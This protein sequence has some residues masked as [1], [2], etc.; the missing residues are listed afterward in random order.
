MTAEHIDA[1]AVQAMAEVGF[2]ITGNTP[3]KLDWGRDPSG[4]WLTGLT[5]ASSSAA[6]CFRLP[7]TGR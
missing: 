5:Q 6:S 2:D 3:R 1:T 4:R 7:G